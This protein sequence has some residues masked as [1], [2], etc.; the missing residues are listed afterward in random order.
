M[1]NFNAVSSTF[2]QE[3]TKMWV[4]EGEESSKKEYM[5]TALEAGLGRDP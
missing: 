4:L 5:E 2:S 1:I 3:V